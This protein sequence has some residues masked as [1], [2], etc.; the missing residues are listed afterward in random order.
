MRVDFEIAVAGERDR[1]AAMRGNLVEH[2]V[3]EGDAGVD[4]ARRGAIEIDGDRDLRLLG[5]AH[6]FGAAVRGR[7]RD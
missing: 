7:G 1:E 6:H 3:E 5:V 4:P 2:V